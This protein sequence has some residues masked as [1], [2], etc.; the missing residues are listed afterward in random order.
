MQ[1]K[2]HFKILG[3]QPCQ[4]CINLKRIIRKL[5]VDT[6]SPFIAVKWYLQ[7]TVMTF[8]MGKVLFILLHVDYLVDPGGCV[9]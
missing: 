4:Q 5:V 2:R 8:K 7:K 3:F 9:V 1:L 6:L